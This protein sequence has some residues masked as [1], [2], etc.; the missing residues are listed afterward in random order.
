MIVYTKGGRVIKQI[1]TKAR[2]VTFNLDDSNDS[3]ISKQLIL[4]NLFHN[5][6]LLDQIYIEGNKIMIILQ[7]RI[8]PINIGILHDKYE[9]IYNNR[10]YSLYV[11]S[12]QVTGG[13]DM[14]K[15]EEG[16]TIK[17][18]AFYGLNLDINVRE[19]VTVI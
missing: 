3:N 1:L 19:S 12:W 2:N 17:R 18:K 8:K 4:H 9:Y 14:P 6:E 5:P 7:D 10:K 15:M 11:K 16:S 13:W